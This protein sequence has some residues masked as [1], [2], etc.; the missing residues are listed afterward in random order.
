MNT[1]HRPQTT[2]H[3][4]KIAG[5]YQIK[6]N[7]NLESASPVT[8]RFYGVVW[9]LILFAVISI[10][11]YAQEV[12]IKE[13]LTYPDKFDA[14]Y[15]GVQGEA[16]GEALNDNK[17]VWLNISDQGYNIG[18]FV[19]EKSEITKIRYWGNYTAEGDSVKI[20]G[21]FSK[22]C[23]LHQE[24]DIHASR[25]EIAKR[26]FLRKEVLS[27]AKVKLTIVLFVICLAVTVIY[28]IKS[29]KHR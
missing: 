9:G 14:T 20:K 29:F 1:D 10:S 17:G 27:P 26:G 13:L 16:I 18:V 28:L 7:S 6:R 21:T 24:R 25:I 12:S 4:R 22:N 3:R 2:D 15:V 23:S 19:R 11:S 8:V 5:R